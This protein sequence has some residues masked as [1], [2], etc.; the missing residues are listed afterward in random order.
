MKHHYYPSLDGLRTIAVGIV[1]AAHGGVSYFR[2]GGVGVDIFFVLS[3]FLIT[4]ILISEWAANA[5][6]SYR[7]FYVRRLLRLAPCLFLTCAFYAATYYW[8]NGNVPAVP[9]LAALSY[10]ANWIRGLYDYNLSWLTHC[11]SLAI[12][13][14]FYFIW[15]W[16]IMLLE[17]C[18]RDPVRK[19]LLLICGALLIAIYRAGMVGIYTDERINYGIDT[20]MDTLMFGAALAYFARSLALNGP[21]SEPSAKW[22]SRALAPAALIVLFAIPNIVTWYSPWM[23]RYGYVIAASASMIV[24]ADL[25]TSRYS[26]FTRPL[27]WA[28]LLFIGKIS[29]G[30]YLLHLPVYYIVEHLL[31]TASLITRLS[32]K[33]SV[34]VVLAT[35][36][37]YLFEKHFLR[38][39]SHFE[40]PTARIAPS[41]KVV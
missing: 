16:T 1:L 34:S 20:R 14:Q 12:E 21:L 32:I 2:S 31:P 8:L 17:R 26:L 39:K 15:P 9:I 13:E 4:N 3:G 33:I 24:I 28:P 40:R 29:Y 27:S 41:Q 10:T 35:A 19:G 30:L 5:S 36:S 22:L 37:F 11:W 18:V 7:N 23:G 6:I 38:L 25:V